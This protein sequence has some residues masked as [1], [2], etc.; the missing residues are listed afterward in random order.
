MLCALMDC[1][2]DNEHVSDNLLLGIEATEVK[3]FYKQF[4]SR[5]T[6]VLRRLMS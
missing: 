2:G 1:T 5:C 4:E 6:V 3:S